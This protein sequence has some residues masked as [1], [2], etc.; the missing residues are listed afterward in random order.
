MT[1]VTRL[2]AALRDFQVA[3]DRHQA[4]VAGC[5]E[6][7][8]RSLV[9]LAAAYDGVAAREFA[10]HWARTVSRLQ[11]YHDGTRAIAAVLVARLS[12]LEEADRHGER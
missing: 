2:A 4:E 1:D 11:D 3:L 5:R 9:R 8:E 10:A 6:R 12:S 7:L